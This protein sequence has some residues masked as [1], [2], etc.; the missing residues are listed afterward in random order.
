[1]FICR[2]TITFSLPFFLLLQEHLIFTVCLHYEYS[3]IEDTMDE[4]KE[5]NVG[6]PLIAK[7]GLHPGFQTQNCLQTRCMPGYPFHNPVESSP[8]AAE[9]YTPGHCQPSSSPGVH[10]PSCACSNSI[11]QA[12]ACSC[13][14]TARMLAPRHQVQ[15]Y[16]PTVEKQNVPVETT[17]DTVE[18]EFLLSDSLSFSEQQ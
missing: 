10:H 18:L 17:D 9:Y 13:S 7:L 14:G 5:I 1:M 12:E 16:S 15:H 11:T 8:E 4:R 3:G 2:G 6:K